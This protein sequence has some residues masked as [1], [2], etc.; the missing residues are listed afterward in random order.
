MGRYNVASTRPG[1]FWMR[2]VA[3]M[4]D[5]IVMVPLAVVGFFLQGALVLIAVNVAVMLYKPLMEGL[6]GATIGKMVLNLRV[7]DPEGGRIG[8][9]GG[10]LRS[11]VFIIPAV[12][13]TIWNVQLEQAGLRRGGDPEAMEVFMAD[14]QLLMILLAASG[15][16]MII[17]CLAVAFTGHKRGIHDFIADSYVIYRNG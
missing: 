1:G 2:V 16:A 17:S 9:F 6:A 8:L 3:Y 13:G 11:A 4:I 15:L 5:T 12:F 10:L 7:I 14:N